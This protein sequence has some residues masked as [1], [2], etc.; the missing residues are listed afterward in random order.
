M[1]VNE[2]RAKMDKR[3]VKAN[4]P[5][6]DPA[7]ATQRMDRQLAKCRLGVAYI[8]I[9]K[10][11]D[12]LLFGKYN[13]R[14]QV[15]KE[16]N[17]LLASFKKEGILAMREDT[18]IPIIVSSTRLKS[19]FQFALNFNE[20]EE[21]PQLQLKDAHTIVVAS[22]QHRVAAL[23]K[24][25]KNVMDE[26]ASIEKR[27]H[28]INEMN[29]PT[30]EHIAEYN[31]LRSELGELQGA[32]VLMGK[33]G[34]IVY[35]E[36]AL[37]ADGEALANHLSRNK[38]LHEY[39]ETFEELLSNILRLV[40]AAY[41]NAPEEERIAAAQH[42][43]QLQRD[44]TERQKNTRLTKI[45]SYEKLVLTLALDLLPLGSHFRRRREFRITWLARSIDVVMGMFI[46]FIQFHTHILRLLASNDTFPDY[47]TAV[48]KLEEWRQMIYDGLANPDTTIFNDVFDDMSIQVNEQFQNVHFKDVGTKQ[49]AFQMAL[50]KNRAIAMECHRQVS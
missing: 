41:N 39:K 17:K 5:T 11:Q 37:L 14:P 27:R 48:A 21:V 38:S 15:D 20:E 33:W 1:Q 22:G 45:L 13:D 49:A 32:L 12:T 2:L 16:V 23:K 25:S 42:E 8:D 26:I 34:I 28:K 10:I 6:N 36:D 50:I 9:L 29:K 31:R 3:P 35:N 44:N 24:Y 47:A 40:K 4:T 46:Q 18:A 19:G 7:Q 30:E 43:L